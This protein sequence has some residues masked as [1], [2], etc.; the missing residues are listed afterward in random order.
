MKGR[1]LPY[2]ETKS[3]TL[4]GN[5]LRIR[6]EKHKINPHKKVHTQGEGSS[7]S[8]SLDIEAFSAVITVPL[9]IYIILQAEQNLDNLPLLCKHFA[10]KQRAICSDHVNDA[11][12]LT[13]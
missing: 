1:T 8:F 13:Y 4:V 11:D 7:I 6:K 9:N 12:G 10:C 3:N 2:N 5:T